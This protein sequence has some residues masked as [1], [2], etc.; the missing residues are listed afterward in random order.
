MD[1]AEGLAELGSEVAIAA[2]RDLAAQAGEVGDL[3][4]ELLT[5]VQAEPV[6]ES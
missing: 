5:E 6:G 3:C 1:A 4:R 2:L